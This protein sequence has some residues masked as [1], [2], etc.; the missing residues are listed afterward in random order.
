M[1]VLA[2]VSTAARSVSFPMRRSLSEVAFLN[3]RPLQVGETFVYDVTLGALNAGTQSITVV[4]ETNDWDEPVYRIE[5][6][7]HTSALLSRVYHFRDHKVTYIRKRDLLPVRYEKQLEDRAYRGDFVVDFD[8]DNHTAAVWRNGARQPDVAMPDDVLDELSMIY[9]LRS[10]EMR[11]GDTYE[12]TFFTGKQLIPVSLLVK[13][14]HRVA[15]PAPVGK[16]DVYRLESEDGYVVWITA[17]EHRIPVRIEAPAKVFG[18]LVAT[19][20]TCENV[21]GLPNHTD[22]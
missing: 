9:Y 1:V 19:L 13:S 12:F 5:S 6:D 4:E 22:D 7:A 14:R 11:I 3:P 16:T 2:G 21:R 18:R 8:R 15:V 10:K 17:D 20:R